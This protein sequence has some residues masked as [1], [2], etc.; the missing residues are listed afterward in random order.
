MHAE[1]ATNT[2]P[3]KKRIC[4]RF[5]TLIESIDAN[6]MQVFLYISHAFDPLSPHGHR[7]NGLHHQ[8][9]WTSDN[10]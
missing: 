9:L 7:E 5:G 1:K 10:C 2:R 6:P 4:K 8:F 3:P